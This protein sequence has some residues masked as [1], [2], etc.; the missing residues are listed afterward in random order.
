[1]V[2]FSFKKTVAPKEVVAPLAEDKPKPRQI[3]AISA[4]G[5]TPLIADL[6]DVE[7]NAEELVIPCAPLKKTSISCPG[8]PKAGAFFVSIP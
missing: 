7:V 8:M 6:K 4:I 1:M 5:S 3:T 2:S